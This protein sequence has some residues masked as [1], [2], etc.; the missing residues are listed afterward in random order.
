[1]D[2]ST[3][4]VFYVAVKDAS[5][6]LGR[7]KVI[8]MYNDLRKYISERDGARFDCF[9]VDEVGC[10]RVTVQF[11]HPFDVMAFVDSTAWQNILGYTVD[12]DGLHRR[13]D[14]MWDGG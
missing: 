5:R 4:L 1:M 8:E 9:F 14:W 13:R 6:L 12:R 10:D 7:E 2:Y 3:T 11:R